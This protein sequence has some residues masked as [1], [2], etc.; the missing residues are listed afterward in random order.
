MF[1]MIGGDGRE[2]GPVTADQLREWIAENRINGQTL[3]QEAGTDA[4]RPASSFFEFE[5]DLT[6]AAV[7]KAAAALSGDGT[8]APEDGSQSFPPDLESSGAVPSGQSARVASYPDLQ[9]AVEGP[10][11]ISV[12]ECLGHGWLLFRTHAFLILAATGLVWSLDVLG[13]AVPNGGWFVSRVL[14]GAAYGGLTMLILRLYRNQS[15][16]L[17]DLVSCFDSRFFT[18]MVVYMIMEILGHLGVALLILPGLFLKIIWVFALALAADR[19]LGIGSA[20]EISRRAASARFLSVAGLLFVAYL[21]HL[22][23]VTFSTI[24]FSMD[25]MTLIG[26]PKTNSITEILEKL[27]APESRATVDQ[28]VQKNQLQQQ[29]VLLLNLPLALPAVLYAY[30]TLFGPRR[31]ATAG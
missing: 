8:V 19:R 21:P 15:R 11:R 31:G 13:M 28:M 26:D 24:Q 7:Q 6:S 30:E 2:Y 16:G 17:A 5:L 12:S 10:A 3:I 1:K 9:E 14:C 23:F 25:L 27:M 29:L 4:W 20:L 18:L 22:L